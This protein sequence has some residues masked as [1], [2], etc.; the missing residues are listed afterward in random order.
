MT[1]LELIDKRIAD[2]MIPLKLC[3]VK[4][5][6]EGQRTCTCEPVDG[7]ADILEVRL[8]A[9]MGKDKGFVLI[10]KKDSYVYVGFF[11]KHAGVI[12]L[13]EVIDKVMIDIEQTSMLMDQDGVVFNGGDLHGMCKKQQVMDNY[14]SLKQYAE[15]LKAATQAV[16]VVCDMLVPTTSTTFQAAMAAFSINIQDVENTKVKH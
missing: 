15:A 6:D 1:I 12:L 13:T 4:D 9:S 11:N 10:P 8:Q 14:N 2:F 5:I 3:K 7:D 16:A